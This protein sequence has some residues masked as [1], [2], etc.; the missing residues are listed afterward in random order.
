MSSSRRD[1]PSFQVTHDA[2]PPE[3]LV[4]GFSSF[5]LAGVIAADFIVDQLE[6][7]ETGHVSTEE[8]PAITPF[9][10]GTPRHHTRLFSRPGVDVAVLVNE[11]FVPRWATDSFAAAILEWTDAHG[12]S[13]ITILSGAQFPHDPDHH[14]VSY[15]A[16][17]D[18]PRDR[19]SSAAI[20]PMGGGF[21]DGVNASLVGRGMDSALRVGVLITPDHAQ[22][23]DMGAAVR[24]VEAATD[25]YD[26][27]I[28]SSA[29]TAFA[30]EVDQYYRDLEAKVEAM[31][32][33]DRSED[34]MFM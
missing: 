32:D 13:E 14:E 21:L 28:D 8:L 2:E 33:A 29:L 26:L 34:R 4:A 24:L 6:L 3:R 19:L 16:T 12:V 30:D 27:G 1:S 18:Y 11:L 9:E 15:V 10:D 5:G 17:R 20:S 25:L 7:E 31:E 23:P 22:V